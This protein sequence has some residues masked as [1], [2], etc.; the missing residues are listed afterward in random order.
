MAST[1]ESRVNIN[2]GLNVDEVQN[3][4]RTIESQFN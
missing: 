2:V 4:I 3:R 1:V